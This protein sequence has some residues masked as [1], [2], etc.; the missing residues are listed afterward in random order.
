M[1]QIITILQNPLLMSIFINLA[2]L[3]PVLSWFEVKTLQSTQYSWPF[4]FFFFNW[5][6]VEFP[7]ALES[8]NNITDTVCLSQGKPLSTSF[9]TPL[10]HTHT[11]T[12]IYIGLFRNSQRGRPTNVQYPNEN[13]PL[14]CFNNP[15]VHIRVCQFFPNMNFFN[16]QRLYNAAIQL[17]LKIVT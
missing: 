9:Q 3:T 12:H 13:I 8:S 15:C 7:L 11:H 6:Y 5:F 17:S 10:A 16:F 4:R 1:G 2:S 14:F